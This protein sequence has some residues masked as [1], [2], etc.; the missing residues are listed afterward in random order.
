MCF[1]ITLKIHFFTMCRLYHTYPPT[2]KT[3]VFN[4]LKVSWNLEFTREVLEHTN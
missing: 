2:N 1:N 3:H 4:D